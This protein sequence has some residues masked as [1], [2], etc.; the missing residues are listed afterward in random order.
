MITHFNN[1]VSTF[2]DW[3]WWNQEETEFT[4]NL[5][6][7]SRVPYNLR[8][9]EGF[10]QRFRQFVI[11]HFNTVVSMFYDWFWRIEMRPNSLKTC[12]WLVKYSTVSEF[13]KVFFSRFRNFVMTDFNIIFFGLSWLVLM[14]RDEPMRLMVRFLPPFCYYADEPRL[15]QVVF[16]LVCLGAQFC[17]YLTIS[18]IICSIL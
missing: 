15:V 9:R 2:L 16:H 4:Q 11:T 5:P 18:L 17:V 6:V 12:Q 3:F 10:F 7:I 1:V 8:V 13:V 14:N